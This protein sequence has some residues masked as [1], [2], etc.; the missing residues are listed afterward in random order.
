MCYY[1]I[2]RVE[3]HEIVRYTGES[4]YEHVKIIRIFHHKTFARCL[5]KQG[6]PYGQVHCDVK[7][8]HSTQMIIDAIMIT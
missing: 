7:T 2:G 4:Q 3:I 1:Q 6:R 5:S 8:K